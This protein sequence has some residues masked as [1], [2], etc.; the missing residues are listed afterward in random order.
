MGHAPQQMSFNPRTQ[1]TNYDYER[2]GPIRQRHRRLSET[3]T[4]LMADRYRTGAT[5][6][7]LAKEFG[8]SRHTVS[9][10]L[11][12]AGIA[13]RQQSPGDKPIDLMVRL[14]ESGL[15]LAMVGN[16]VGAS[17]GTVR[18]YLLINGV[19]MRDSHGQKR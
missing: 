4:L 3:Q 16:R 2:T 18:R 19:Q 10:R 5:L 6:Y 7:Q 15:S 17:P 13:M 11:K 9:E 14:Y 12:K 1:V 8:I